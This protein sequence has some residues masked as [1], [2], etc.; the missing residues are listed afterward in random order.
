MFCN[1]LHNHNR[2]NPT[3]T[4]PAAAPR[5]AGSAEFSHNPQD[6]VV[7]EPGT[8]T[9]GGLKS[10]DVG[11]AVDKARLNEQL[12]PNADGNYIFEQGTPGFHAANSFSAVARTIKFF[13]EGTGMS[14]GWS[15]KKPQ[16]DVNSDAGEMLN[17]YYQKGEGSVNFFHSTDPKTQ[18]VVWSGDSGEVVS[19]EVGH[20]ILD[21]F[22][23]AYLMNWRTDCGAFHESFGD[24]LA[25]VMSLQDDRVLAKVVEQTG[26]DLTK[27]NLAANLGEELGITINDT[28]GK[29][30]TGGDYTRTAI[31]NLKWADPKTL[32]NNPEDPNE[33]GSE[34]HNFSRL[35]TGAFYDVFTGIVNENRAAGMDAAQALREASNEGLRMLGRLVKGA[36]RFDFTYKDM[37]KAFI[38]SDRD[39]NE[40]KHVDLITQSYKNRGILPA[41]FSLSE[42]GPSPVPRSLTDEQAAVQKDLVPL[43][44][45]FGNFSGAVVEVP[46]DQDTP[47]FAADDAALRADMKH[48]IDAGRI[49]Y[50]EPHQRLSNKDLFDKNGQPYIG[51]LRWKDGQPV[52]E[53]NHVVA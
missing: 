22:R 50:T 28:A 6:K 46:R 37:A 41:D 42:V 38:A 1:T 40:G 51:V 33:L 12:A 26:G 31:N 43:V 16:L 29:N 48:L 21:A 13:E 4:R 35:W 27:P 11:P 34:V 45:D 9:V 53:R 8:Y 7:L 25:L 19:H 52:I 24:M 49:L 23:P 3:Q 39:G 44:G 14:I 5:Q 15:F 32:P 17:A 2:I 47:R 10:G 36:P 30:R 20:A 18:Q